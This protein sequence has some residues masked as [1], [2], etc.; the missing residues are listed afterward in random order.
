[1]AKHARLIDGYVNYSN[2]CDVAV[3]LVIIGVK[4]LSKVWFLYTKVLS[5]SKLECFMFMNIIYD[6]LKQVRPT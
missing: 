5:F 4:F 6:I 1:M 2:K 3:T